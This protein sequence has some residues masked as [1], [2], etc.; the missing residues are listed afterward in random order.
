MGGNRMSLEINIVTEN[1]MTNGDNESVK[2]VTVDIDGEQ[3]KEY[4]SYPST[5]EDST[6]ESEVETDL[7]NKGYTWS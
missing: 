6:I 7:T 5:T 1:F 4:Y 3:V 2:S